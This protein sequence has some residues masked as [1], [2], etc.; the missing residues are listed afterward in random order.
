MIKSELNKEQIAKI[1]REFTELHRLKE[2]ILTIITNPP[3]HFR[4][5]GFDT[6]C[7]WWASEGHYC[8]MKDK[9]LASQCYFVLQIIDAFLTSDYRPTPQLNS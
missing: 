3:C 4:N 2:R 1:E 8:S 6:S 9:T 5:E 7:G